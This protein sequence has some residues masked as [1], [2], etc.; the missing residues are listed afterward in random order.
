MAAYETKDTLPQSVDGIIHG[1]VR[2][3]HGLNFSCT[4]YFSIHEHVH[5]K[6]DYKFTLILP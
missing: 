6:K 5:D 2:A 1:S 3:A 4:A